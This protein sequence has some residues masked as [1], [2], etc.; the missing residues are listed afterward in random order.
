MGRWNKVGTKIPDTK[1]LLVLQMLI[2]ELGDIDYV[3]GVSE[4]HQV[5]YVPDKMI[6]IS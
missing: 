3:I 5:I 6:L 2:L 1:R 4:V